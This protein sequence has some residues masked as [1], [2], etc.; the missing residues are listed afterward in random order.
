MSVAKQKRTSDVTERFSLSPQNLKKNNVWGK[1]TLCNGDGSKFPNT[2]DLKGNDISFGRN[3]TCDICLKTNQISGDHGKIQKSN[4]ENGNELIQF[5][6]QST[7]GTWINK[8]HVWKSKLLITDGD[9]IK[10]VPAS[11]R[12]NRKEVAYILI[13]FDADK[14]AGSAAY[15]SK[16]IITGKLGDG[17]YADVFE[18][19]DRVTLSKYAMKC[20]DKSKWKSY[21]NC[22]KRKI[23]LLD[24]GIIY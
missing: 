12:R 16:Y 1:L 14:N 18:V 23:T 9:E 20:I 21:Q 13:I 3:K 5:I 19:I 10:F 4:D 8:V 24:E 11:Q 22:T 2:I 15:E 17:A 7:N 6:D